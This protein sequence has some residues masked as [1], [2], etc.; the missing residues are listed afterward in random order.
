MLSYGLLLIHLLIVNLQFPEKVKAL[1]LIHDVL[2]LPIEYGL[3]EARCELLVLHHLMLML[4][5]LS[6]WATLK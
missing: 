1:T 6:H 2:N 5:V 4:H 3:Q